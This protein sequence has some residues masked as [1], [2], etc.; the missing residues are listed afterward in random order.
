MN[1]RSVPEILAL[2]NASIAQNNRRLPKELKAT[3]SSGLK[4]AMVP[5]RTVRT[6]AVH[7]GVHAAPP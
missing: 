5:C 2:A 3:R 1:Y 6:V 4:P 7:G